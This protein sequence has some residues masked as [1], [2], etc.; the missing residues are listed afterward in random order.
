V[1]QYGKP[2][3]YPFKN[4]LDEQEI[5]PIWQNAQGEVLLSKQRLNHLDK[6]TDK[7]NFNIYQFHSRFDADWS[8]ILQKP[9]FVRV[10]MNLVSHEIFNETQELNDHLSAEQISGFA[11]QGDIEISQIN[12][13]KA[14]LAEYEQELLSQWLISLLVIL[15][16]LERILSEYSIRRVNDLTKAVPEKAVVQKE[17]RASI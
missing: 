15:W 4:T 13:N 12:R 14:L 6:V 2:V 1:S 5:L 17:S 16:I 10:L 7:N 9:Q 3:E 11:T 8:N